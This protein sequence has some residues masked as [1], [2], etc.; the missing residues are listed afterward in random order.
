[1][2]LKLLVALLFALGALFASS[3]AHASSQTTHAC[4]PVGPRTAELRATTSVSCPFARAVEAHL[5]TGKCVSVYARIFSP[6]TGKAYRMHYGMAGSKLVV[7]TGKG[8]HGS[9]LTVWITRKR[10]NT[11]TC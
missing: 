1:M 7:A 2:N 6:T 11:R 10:A 8:A 9:T 5:Y 3:V 4:K